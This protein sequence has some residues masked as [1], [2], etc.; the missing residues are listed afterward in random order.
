MSQGE[1]NWLG[2]LVW[3][4]SDFWGKTSACRR[5]SIRGQKMNGKEEYV[6]WRRGNDG[7][8]I[9]KHLGVFATFEE[10]AK[11][12]EEQKYHAPPKRNGI[13]DWKPLWNDK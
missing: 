6:L 7:R 4:D 13:Y 10:A 3:E 12:A 8:V 9:P 11:E 1:L 2:P 5:F